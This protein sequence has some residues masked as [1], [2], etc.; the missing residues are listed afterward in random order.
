MK[1]QRF[2]AFLLSSDCELESE[3]HRKRAALEG[4]VPFSVPI[5][6]YGIVI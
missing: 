5:V 1:K 3:K 2:S 4:I 6:L